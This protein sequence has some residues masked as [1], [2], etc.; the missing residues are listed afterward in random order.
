MKNN[1]AIICYDNALSRRIAK[2]LCEEFDMRYFD[3]YDMFNFDNSPYSFAELIKLNGEDYI[4]KSMRSILKSEFGFTNTMLI[5]D[6][7]IIYDNQDLFDS[8]KDNNLVLYLKSDFKT[9]FAQRE[10]VVFRSEE[11][12]KY[13]SLELDKLC[14]IDMKIENQL[15]DIVFDVEGLTFSQIKEN[16]LKTLQTL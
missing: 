14:E 2:S 7:K 3:M 4:T 6:T 5:A 12:K 10:H 15:A 13:F 16:I 11:E 8:I 1:L 9:E